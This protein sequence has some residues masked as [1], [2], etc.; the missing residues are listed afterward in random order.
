[1]CVGCS[2]RVRFAVDRGGSD[3]SLSANNVNKSQNDAQLCAQHP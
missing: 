1:M 3:W 2:V